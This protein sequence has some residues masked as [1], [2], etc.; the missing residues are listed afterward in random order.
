MSGTALQ[1]EARLDLRAAGS[2][3]KEILASRGGDLALDAG[4]TEHIGALAVQVIRAAARTWAEAGH[5]LRFEHA[6]DAL[7]GDLAQLG[8]TPET[9][10]QWEAPA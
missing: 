9:L 5:A 4:A 2:L 6:S 3:A 1:L 7:A 10:T 8:F